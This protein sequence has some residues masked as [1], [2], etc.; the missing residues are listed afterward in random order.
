MFYRFVVVA[1][2][3]ITIRGGSGR[4]FVGGIGT[5]ASGLLCVSCVV[6]PDAI[7]SLAQGESVT[8]RKRG[9]NLDGLSS[10]GRDRAK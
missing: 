8:V 7:S 2:H 6:G 4:G 1:T 3:G 5:S 9:R 10:S